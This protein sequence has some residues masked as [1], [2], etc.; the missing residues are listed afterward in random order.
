[1]RSSVLFQWWCYLDF[2]LLD[3]WQ[4]YTVHKEYRCD[5]T[6]ECHALDVRFS[7][8]KERKVLLLFDNAVRCYVF[9]L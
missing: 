6:V 2:N 3:T 8:S 7:L 5:P 9:L 4:E 1:V